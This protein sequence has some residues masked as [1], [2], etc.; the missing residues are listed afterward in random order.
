[1]D[2]DNAC[3]SRT[4]AT[5]DE[6]AINS[7]SASYTE[8]RAFISNTRRVANES[9]D[10]QF[11]EF[12]GKRKLKFD[13][14][15]MINFFD[16]HERC[17]QDECILHTMEHMTEDAAGIMLDF[18]YSPNTA[19]AGTIFDDVAIQ[20][21]ITMLA[22]TIT[23]LITEETTQ[24]HSLDAQ[25][26]ID[27]FCNVS[28]DFHG[29]S[30]SINAKA[31]AIVP[32]QSYHVFVIRRSVISYEESRNCYK[33]GIHILIP[34]LW[35]SRNERKTILA[36]LCNDLAKADCPLG[37]L[38]D[39]NSP[40]VSPYLL[41]SCKP[42]GK[43]YKLV[44]A[45]RIS[46]NGSSDTITPLDVNALCDGYNAPAAENGIKINLVYELCL[47]ISLPTFRGQPTWLRKRVVNISK[48]FQSVV[49]RI[50]SAVVGPPSEAR[51][52]ESQINDLI[53]SD[54]RAA[55]LYN[56][57]NIL[58][59]EFAREYDKWLSILMIIACPYEQCCA[60]YKPIAQQFSK[61]ALDK[62]D[63][64][65]FESAWITICNR[66][67]H[68]MIRGCGRV[69]IRTLEYWAR[70]ADPRAFD[71]AQR[72]DARSFLASCIYENGGKLTNAI[73]AELQY[74]LYHST[75]AVDTDTPDRSA[76]NYWFEF[77]TENT[78]NIAPGEIYKWRQLRIPHNLYQ[79]IQKRIHDMCKEVMREIQTRADHARDETMREHYLNVGKSLSA[80][81]S[82]LQSEGF[83]ESTIKCATHLFNIRGFVASL[84]K[85]MNVI[86]VGNGVLE[87]LP[88]DF[89]DRT[90]LQNYT[91]RLISGYH[92]LRVMNHTS[93][94][95]VP[96]NPESQYVRDIMQAYSEIY[97]ERD[98]RDFIL[99]YLSTWLDACDVARILL[100][101]GGG[102]S[103]GKT[104]SVL[105]PQRVLGENYV[106]MLRMQLLVEDHEKAREANSA[107]MQLK[108]LRGGYFDEANEGAC[109]NPARV[110]A[111][112]TPGLQSGRDLYSSE[113]QFKNTANCIAISNYDFIV[114]ATDNGTWDRLRYYQCKSRFV[115]NPDPTSPFEHKI[116]TEL[117]TRWT[118]DPNYRSAMLSILVHYRLRL[119]KEYNGDIRTIPSPTIARE[120]MAFRIKQDPIT[121]FVN[122]RVVI[123]TA[124]TD[125]LSVVI[126]RYNAWYRET[127]GI[128]PRSSDQQVTMFQNSRLGQFIKLG[129]D[130]THS[131]EG[132]RV[133]ER[134][135]RLR[136]DERLL[137]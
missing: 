3:V 59:I 16:L 85:Q 129:S 119:Q 36:G 114:N 32:D 103:N 121:R 113:E 19:P 115:H 83:C 74:R 34:E 68:R 62:W 88:N 125:K 8:L 111:V 55:Y 67:A 136:E 78:E 49:D 101:L 53:A 135:D 43:I 92:E 124:N 76:V 58:P 50:G 22:R 29:A 15:E 11:L 87:F 33:D 98:V 77:V 21:I 2:F 26:M 75:Y 72:K 123:S 48:R 44:F 45:A 46:R 66:S 84:D 56:L 14:N 9:S 93:T 110:K 20:T 30:T 60:Q 96:Y 7:A 35:F 47:T 133:R 97:G 23:H 104:W 1:M 5:A 116:R 80:S 107:L 41:G 31:P 82:K 118:E 52:I 132:I 17:R 94:D 105:F 18:D 108:D 63:P 128:R 89:S 24:T 95:Y 40:S 117:T 73:I 54:S 112:V 28:D 10:Y 122:E 137:D 90:D 71:D 61:R 64:V 99:F 38:I 42:L 109:L 86:G 57:L 37:K 25:E 102:G 27:E 39:R 91:P 65:G 51:T 120:S 79:S 134:G 127:M 131:V 100:L 130:G 69:T 70:L 106:K 4:G 13:E 81:T 126:D 6:D 12:S